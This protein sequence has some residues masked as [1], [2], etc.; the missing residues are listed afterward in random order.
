MTRTGTALLTLLMLAAGPAAAGCDVAVKPVAFGSIDVAVAGG[1]ES[2]LTFTRDG[3][4]AAATPVKTSNTKTHSAPLPKTY[5][6]FLI[7]SLPPR[8]TQ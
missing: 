7:V 4:L 8:G 2:I 6:W 3:F 1:V 5:P